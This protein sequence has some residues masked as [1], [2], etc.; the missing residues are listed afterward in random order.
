VPVDY[1]AAFRAE[2]A[3]D[4][5][6]PFVRLRTLISMKEDVGRGRDRDDIEHLR[7]IQQELGND[8]RDSG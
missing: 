1:D 6:V 2:V 5:I 7:Q 8:E 3:P 4:L